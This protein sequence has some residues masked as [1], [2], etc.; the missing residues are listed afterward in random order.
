MQLEV[1]NIELNLLGVLC[2]SS[3]KKI[4]ILGIDT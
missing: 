2:L 1:Y 4:K 3:I